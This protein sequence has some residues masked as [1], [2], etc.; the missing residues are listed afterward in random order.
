M[1]SGANAFEIRDIGRMNLGAH[2]P[3]AQDV[4][5]LSALWL[6]KNNNSPAAGRKRSDRPKP[7]GARR[8]DR[9]DRL[10]RHRRHSAA[11]PSVLSWTGFFHTLVCTVSPRHEMSRGSPT[12]TDNKQPFLDAPFTVIGAA[13][14]G[15]SRVDCRAHRSAR[16]DVHCGPGR[17]ARFSQCHRLLAW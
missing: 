3:A 6:S 17:Y 7:F 15:H 13:S 2:Q 8:H 1:V 12:F 16:V 4:I 10:G 14:S 11:E 5:M 9:R